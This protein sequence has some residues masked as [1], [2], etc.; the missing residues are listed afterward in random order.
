[1]KDYSGHKIKLDDNLSLNG[2]PY[3]LLKELNW[4]TNDD[5]VIMDSGEIHRTITLGKKLSG[6]EAIE[7]MQKIREDLSDSNKENQS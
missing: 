4:N 7:S 2:L 1:M 5:I 6:K 3:T